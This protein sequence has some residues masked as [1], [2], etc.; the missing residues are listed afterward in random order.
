[1]EQAVKTAHSVA[2]SY[3][4]RDEIEASIEKF[5]K[6]KGLPMPKIRSGQRDKADKDLYEKLIKEAKKKKISS[7]KVAKFIKKEFKKRDGEQLGEIKRKTYNHFLGG[8]V[9]IAAD[10]HADELIKHM[11]KEGHRTVDEREMI[12]LLKSKKKASIG[13]GVLHFD[14]SN[15]KP[16]S[17]M[18][19]TAKAYDYAKPRKLTDYVFKKEDRKDKEDREFKRG[20][21]K[22]AVAKKK[23]KKQAD[24]KITKEQLKEVKEK[25]KGKSYREFA[26]EV[27]KFIK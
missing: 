11:K 4:K 2:K 17:H 27:S 24:Y 9:D 12:S 19:D 1:M 23:I 6:S 25:T 16:D 20:K 3:E 10:E 8:A 13:R 22:K 21:Y 15:I 18:K 14:A 7:R 26:A 5:Y